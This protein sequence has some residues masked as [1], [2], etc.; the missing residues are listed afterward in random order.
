MNAYRAVAPRRWSS[1]TERPLLTIASE[2]ADLAARFGL[3][4][5]R[6]FDDLDWYEIAA[7]DL[8]SGLHVHLRRY[9]GN[10]EPGTTAYVDGAVDLRFAALEL[11]EALDLESDDLRWTAALDTDS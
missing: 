9:Q 11:I 4:F 6:E 8:K 1:G 2:P 3:Q 5:A 10:P 7:L